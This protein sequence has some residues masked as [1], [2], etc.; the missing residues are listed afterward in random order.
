MTFL[1]V[2]ENKEDSFSFLEY[3]NTK[4]QNI[5]FT[6]ELNVDGKLLFLDVLV[7]NKNTFTTSVYHK[8]TFTGLLTNFRSFIPLGYKIRLIKTLLDRIYKI[9]NTWKG[10]H[11]NVKLCIN[12]L[13]RNLFPKSVIDRNIKEYL[14]KKLKKGEIGEKRTKIDNIQYFKLPFISDFSM[15]TKKKVTNLY[16]RFCKEGSEFRLVFSTTKVRN[17]FFD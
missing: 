13:S 3:L 7:D 4:H 16:K 9:N 6:K 11:E 17:Y 1:Q 2:F 14:D 8:P 15:T 5:T 12:Y 10:F